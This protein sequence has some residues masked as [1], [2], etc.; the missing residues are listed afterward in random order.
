MIQKLPKQKNAIHG[1]GEFQSCILS[2][3]KLEWFVGLC[4]HDSDSSDEV[5]GYIDRIH[6]H[7]AKTMR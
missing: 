1:I 7:D 2:I 4:L 3:Q 5:I 6:E